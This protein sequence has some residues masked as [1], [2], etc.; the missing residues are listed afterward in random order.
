MEPYFLVNSPER[1]QC[2]SDFGFLVA[3]GLADRQLSRDNRYA[4]D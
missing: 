3:D 4:S 1:C 2:W